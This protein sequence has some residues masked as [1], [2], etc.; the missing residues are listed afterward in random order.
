MNFLRTGRKF[1]GETELSQAWPL[2][3]QPQVGE[4]VS[5]ASTLWAEQLG[6]SLGGLRGR[7]GGCKG[8]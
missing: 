7:G 2:A 5:E 3:G 8:L 6:H 1:C 4:Q